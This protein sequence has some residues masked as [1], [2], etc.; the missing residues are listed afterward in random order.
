[1]STVQRILE[2]DADTDAR[3]EALA[4]EKGQ[5][6]SAVVADAIAL[7]DSVIDL[8]GPDIRE[9]IRRLQEFERTGEAIPGTEVNAWIESWGTADELARPQPRKV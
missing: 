1:M 5:N 6:A 9:D 8:E 7:L 4:A 3:I 2:L